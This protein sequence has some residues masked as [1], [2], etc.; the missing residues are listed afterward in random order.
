MYTLFTLQILYVVREAKR[1]LCM[2]ELEGALQYFYNGTVF[3][4]RPNKVYHYVAPFMRLCNN[5]FLQITTGGQKD[6]TDMVKNMPYEEVYQLFHISTDNPNNQYFIKLTDMLYKTQE[7]L[8]FSLSESLQRHKYSNS[9]LAFPIFSVPQQSLACDV[10]VIMPFQNN[11]NYLYHDSIKIVCERINKTCI[12]ADDIYTSEMIINDIWSL[13]HNS[14]VIIADCTG[15]NPNVMYELGIAHT[16]GKDVILITQNIDDIPF[17]LR[18]L[19]HMNYE[20]APHAIKQFEND[21]EKS[22]NQYFE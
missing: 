21:L 10:F 8:G 1:P 18:H 4:N 19:R 2:T 7:T 20:Y 17:D 9:L 13:I 11:F 14:R 22:L 6:V 3:Q 16:L 15:K 5:G 12:R